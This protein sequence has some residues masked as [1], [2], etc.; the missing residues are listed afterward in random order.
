MD[1]LRVVERT[2]AGRELDEPGAEA[3]LVEAD[4]EGA[5]LP[6]AGGARRGRQRRRVRGA[7]VRERGAPGDEVFAANE[8][9]REEPGV[10]FGDE[11]PEGDQVR[12]V[13]LL[14]G[15]ELLLEA[16]DRARIDVGE[17]LQRDVLAA[18]GVERLVDDAHPTFAESAEES[19][20]FRRQKVE[21]YPALER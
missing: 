7:D 8:L 16:E 6:L 18:V 9:H 4:R 3:E 17:D 19:E 21:H 15:A 20:A 5:R 1:L 13:H 2:E 11:L 12:V 10:P 14:E